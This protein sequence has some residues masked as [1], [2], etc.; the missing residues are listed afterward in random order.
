MTSIS[1]LRIC[2]LKFLHL[3]FALLGLFC[4]RVAGAEGFWSHTGAVP[5]IE[6][7]NRRRVTAPDGRRY[8][9]GTRGG[10]RISEVASQRSEDLPVVALPPLWEI[11]WASDSKYVAV[12]A[13]DGGA[14][15][16]WDT[17]IFKVSNYGHVTTF[18]V[19]D[20]VRRAARSFAKCDSP[21]EVNVALVGWEEHGTVA[22]VVAEVPPHSSCQNMGQLRGFRISVN[23]EKVV[24]S[25]SEPVLRTRWAA[26]L[27]LR[28]KK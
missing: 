24:E 20:L 2:R 15:G 21:E 14:V 1:S 12:N 13:S 23:S 27:G 8:I 16:T 3:L 25:L 26:Q 18:P 22:L 6:D 11:I 19:S 5:P 9:V 4:M 28:L 17:T 10:L 7:E